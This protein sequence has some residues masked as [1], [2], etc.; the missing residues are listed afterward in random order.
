MRIRKEVKNTILRWLFGNISLEQLCEF[1][2]R[3][4]VHAAVSNRVE[5]HLLWRLGQLTERSSAYPD[6]IQEIRTI[7]QRRCV[8]NAANN[9]RMDVE[10]RDLCRQLISEGIKVMLL[11]GAAIRARYPELAGRP[12]CDTDILI[13]KV[14]LERSEEILLANGFKVDEKSFTREEY[15]AKHFDLRMIREHHA[16]ELHWAMS[17]LG[18]AGATERSWQ[19]AEQI[20]WGG[21]HVW[22]P[23]LEDQL[24]FS[25]IHISRHVFEGSLRWFGDLVF[26][27]ERWNGLS[28]RLHEAAIDWP[29]RMVDA[30]FT[31]LVDWGYS[32]AGLEDFSHPVSHIDRFLLRGLCR[33]AAWGEDGLGLPSHLWGYALAKWLKNEDTSLVKLLTNVLLLRSL[34]KR[35]DPWAK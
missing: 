17:N 15:L 4:L 27:L 32:T 5:A 33:P 6:E 23:S 30:P 19:R 3:E 2:P 34:G 20:D 12:Q 18:K 8:F 29:I 16:F 13:E 9:L 1:E 28:F 25:S 24:V 22:V 21:C 10:A 7:L 11:K 26:E 35:I 14:H 31:V